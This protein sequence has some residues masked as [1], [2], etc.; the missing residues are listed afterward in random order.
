MNV[1]IVNFYKKSQVR[2][3]VA[4][5]FRGRVRY[6]RSMFRW[7]KRRFRPVRREVSFDEVLVDAINIARV[8]ADRLEGKREMPISKARLVGVGVVFLVVA[9]WF[10]Y[11]LFVIQI[12]EGDAFYARSVNNSLGQA[13]IIAERG[14]IL[15]RFGEAL[16]WNDADV[17]KEHDFPVRA[18]TTRNGLGSVIGYVNAPRKDAKGVFYRTEYTGIAGIEESANATLSGINGTRYFEEDV[19]GEIIAQH[20]IAPAQAGGSVTLSLDAELTEVMHDI[21]ASTTEMT[22]FRSGA[23]A[24]M[25]VH[26][27][28]IIA[29]AGFP[30][31]NPTV[32]A[33]GTNREKIAEL[34]NDARS[35]LMDKIIAGTYIPGSIVKPFVAYAALAEGVVTPETTIYSDGRLVVPNR[36]N[37]DNPTIFHD[38]KAHGSLNLVRAIAQSGDVYFYTV[39]GGTDEQRGLGITKFNTWMNT[40]GFGSPTGIALSGERAGVVPNPEWKQE[41]FGDEWR[42]GDTYNTSIGQ[43]GWQVT[44]IQMLVAYAALANGGTKFTPTLY[45]D[46]QTP[47]T[48]L[49]LDE[50]YLRVVRQGMREAV[51]TDGGTVRGLDRKDV[52]IAG[53]SGTAE[54]DRAKTKVHTWV[55]GFFPY[56]APKYSFILFMENG[57]YKNQVGAS[58]VMKEVMNWMVEHRPEYVGILP[59][60][61]AQ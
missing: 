14:V 56:E 19:Q 46:T 36:Y 26:T 60:G 54:L 45:K 1:G 23:A 37:P 52:A 58:W 34:S 39:G 12:L 59:E 51:A 27:G 16:A 47:S 9:V 30:S 5:A 53:K 21:I 55:A 43:Y 28:E 42:L 7:L 40:F 15:D 48:D 13:T 10:T 20:T 22:G 18:Y 6:T 38:W 35:P 3:F 11:R 61:D 17:A 2:F 57:P 24:I 44:P 29:L 41:I 25:D 33:D 32:F 31:Y 50:N 4:F 8:D 49:H